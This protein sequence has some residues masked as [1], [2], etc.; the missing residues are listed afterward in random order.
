MIIIIKK[1]F[2]RIF[3]VSLIVMIVSFII[4]MIIG[5]IHTI[6]FYISGISLFLCLIFGVILPELFE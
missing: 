3:I 1:V 2:D 6:A 5:T 4:A